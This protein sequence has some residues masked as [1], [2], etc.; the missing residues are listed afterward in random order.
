MSTNPH[1]TTQPTIPQQMSAV[2]APQAGNATAL[3]RSAHPVPTP[4]ADELLIRIHAAGINR[5]DVLQRQGHYP[6]PDG[7]TSILGLE[8]AGEVVAMGASVK[9]FALGDRVC[10]LLAG[11][12]YAEYCVVPAINALPIPDGL[13]MIEAAALPE[14]FFTVWVNLFERGQLQAGE[15]VLVHGGTSGIGSV[16]IMLAKAFGARVLTTVGSNHKCQAALQIGADAAINYHEQDFVSRVKALTDGQGADVIVDLIAGDYVNRN[17]QAA[18]MFGRIVQIGVQHGQAE[19]VDLMLLLSRCLTHTGSTLRAR[20]AHYKAKIA[21]AL[22]D[23][24]WPRLASGQ[25]KPQIDRV[26]D[27]ADVVAAH[28]YFDGGEHVGKVVLMVAADE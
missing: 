5:P 3:Q 18:A 2:T 1:T 10:A 8:V 26:F 4:N 16:A 14:T 23:Q 7:V 24:V 9:D 25:I 13:S 6:P 12:G 11:G 20:D 28:Q 17:Y 21:Q 19:S 27:L 15:T 22:H